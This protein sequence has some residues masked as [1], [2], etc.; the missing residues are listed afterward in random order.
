MENPISDPAHAQAVTRHDGLDGRTIAF[1]IGGFGVLSGF[2]IFFLMLDKADSPLLFLG[3]LGVASV[4]S[5]IFEGLR[6]RIEHGRVEAGPRTAARLL[7]V[8]VVLII[9]EIHGMSWESLTEF[10]SSGDLPVVVQAVLGPSITGSTGVWLDLVVLL[11]FWVVSGALLALVL[12]RHLERASGSLGQRIQRGASYGA[13]AGALIAPA[14][15]L[16]YVLL[17]WIAR[18]LYLLLFD[19][20]TWLANLGALQQWAD[21]STNW[22]GTLLAWSFTALEQA[23]TWLGPG[24]WFSLLVVVAAAA[25]V[26]WLVRLEA[27]MLA[28][29]LGSALAAALIAPLLL[30]LDELLGMLVRASL[31]WFVPGLV[32][33]ALAPLLRETSDHHR[34]RVWGHVAFASAAVLFVITA[35]RFTT[36]WW[37]L[38][39]AVLLFALGVAVRR[40]PRVD[41]FWL[42]MALAMGVLVCGATLGVQS[43]AS[44]VGVYDG[45]HGLTTLPSAIRRQDKAHGDTEALRKFLEQ[46]RAARMP[47][48]TGGVPLPRSNESL[49]ARLERLRTAH[50]QLEELRQEHAAHRYEPP[51]WTLATPAPAESAAATDDGKTRLVDTVAQAIGTL[52]EVREEEVRHAAANRVLEDM[53]KRLVAIEPPA[54]EL[55]IRPPA[56]EE[57]A[58]RQEFARLHG[59]A[60]AMQ[61]E[62]TT[63]LDRELARMNQAAASLGTHREVRAA[64]ERPLRE[65]IVRWLELALAGSVGY[66]TAIS[67][68]V[69][70]AMQ[71][72]AAP[73]PDPS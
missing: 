60:T 19:P 6:E 44:F 52:R 53:R 71:R 56:A 27:T 21:L 1:L 14:G 69:G 20:T 33:G 50:R 64:A 37:L 65:M 47:A 25:L 13:A 10:A 36:Q 22:I 48:G 15:L 45:M 59:E 61:N 40:A 73:R 31:V 67:L 35:L 7:L 11:G 57:R 9:A 46:Q 26:V 49:A 30:H 28:W 12:L 8:T 43:A 54:I 5:A 58:S 38:G 39:P 63:A 34:P 66:W 42:P 62:L 2:S 23:V 18:G 51:A 3:I 72:H 32:L 4:L 29:I 24:S 17:V 16:V 70:W 41:D 68:L 55:S